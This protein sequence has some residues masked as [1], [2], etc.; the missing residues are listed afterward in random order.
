MKIAVCDAEIT[1]NY[2]EDLSRNGVNEVRCFNNFY[3][4]LDYLSYNTVSLLIIDVTR[5]DATLVDA[6]Y[7]LHTIKTVKL[8][9]KPR[10]IIATTSTVTVASYIKADCIICRP[11][12]KCYFMDTV[13]RLLYTKPNIVKIQSDASKAVAAMGLPK[14]VRG[15]NFYRDIAILVHEDPLGIYVKN[16]LIVTYLAFR[17]MMSPEQVVE[18]LNKSYE[19]AKENRRKALRW[20]RFSLRAIIL[21]FKNIIKK[22]FSKK[23]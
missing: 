1:K 6:F 15:H 9:K 11:I 2:R 17:Y 7:I 12:L 4:L 23:S 21:F 10:K 8:Y 20:K 22:L 13:N 5:K 19:I 3:S 14:D 16:K 18:I